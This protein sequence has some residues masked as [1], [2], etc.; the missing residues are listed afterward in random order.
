[1][2]FNK[3]FI[4][5]KSSTIPEEI[6]NFKENDIILS[7]YEKRLCFILDIFFEYSD[8]ALSK[9]QKIYHDFINLAREDLW[10]WNYCNLMYSAY[11]KKENYMRK[12]YSELYSDY[13]MYWNR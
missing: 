5:I 6:S 12:K 11:L 9:F 3:S 4:G 13:I 8:D 7:Y 1:M 2:F 10:F